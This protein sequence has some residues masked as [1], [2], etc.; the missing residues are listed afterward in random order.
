M[1][2]VSE[3][4]RGMAFLMG[5]DIY[6]VTEYKHMT[7]GN[8]RAFVQLS[9]RSVKTGKT[10][11]NRFR[12]SEQVEMISLDGIKAQYLYHDQGTYHFMNLSDYSQ[13][14]VNEATVGDAKNYLTENLELQLVLHNGRVI[15][16]SLPASVKLTVTESAPGLKGDSATNVQKPATLETGYTVNVPL[17]VSQGDKILVDTRT[18]NYMGRA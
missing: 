13:L 9:Y 7:P 5:N 8:L 4:R 1:I 12:P 18:G 6:V 15:E 3:L 2:Q 11:Q 10:G 17:F 16:I 14:E